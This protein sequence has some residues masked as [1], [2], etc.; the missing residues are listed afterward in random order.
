MTENTRP[1]RKKGPLIQS[2][3][4]STTTYDQTKSS[5]DEIQV[6]RPWNKQTSG[7]TI[8]FTHDVSHS[9]LCA[10]TQFDSSKRESV[11]LDPKVLERKKAKS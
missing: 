1:L 9:Q 10:V 11:L 7:G 6:R 5:K 3:N 4:S 8:N 2:T